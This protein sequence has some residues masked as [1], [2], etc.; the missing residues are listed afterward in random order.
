MMKG[1]R[2]GRLGLAGLAGLIGMAAVV[3][4]LALAG[5]SVREAAATDWSLIITKNQITSTAAD[6]DA[7]QAGETVTI[8][9]T[10]NK[11]VRVIQ[12]TPPHQPIEWP[13]LEIEIGDTLRRA[14]YSD[15]SIN[16]YGHTEHHWEYTVVAA[17]RDVDGISMGRD[18]IK[19]PH[20]VFVNNDY[21]GSGNINDYAARTRLSRAIRDP[22]TH[23]VGSNLPLLPPDNFEVSYRSNGVDLTWDARSGA[24]KYIIYRQNADSLYARYLSIHTVVGGGNSGWRDTEVRRGR[25][26]AYKIATVN[27]NGAGPQSKP[28]GITLPP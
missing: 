23:R 10:F 14:A 4:L 27:R 7:Y 20:A 25:P 12:T 21:R 16:V 6:G 1:I 26:Y 22:L 28:A 17:D 19:S 2:Q 13:E 3:G 11:P 8:T 9:V 18:A 24:T 15:Q 5:L